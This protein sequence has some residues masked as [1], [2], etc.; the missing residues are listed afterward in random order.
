MRLRLVVST[1]A[2]EL[3]WREVLRPGRAVAYSA[4]T[5]VD[6][7]LGKRLHDVGFGVHG[8]A[9]L[10]YGAPVFPAARRRRGSYAIGGPGTI[11]FGSPVSGV[12]E[13]LA[14]GLAGFRVLD[15]G[16]VALRVSGIEPVE[17]PEFGSGRARFR[18]VTPVVMKGAGR[19][20]SGLR[21]TRQ[22]WLLPGEA[23]WA[24]YFQGNLR[25]KAET[26]GLD[27][28]VSLESV[29]WVGPKRSFAVGE[30]AKPGAAV[31]VEIAGAPE[32]L[33][34]LW[35]WGLGQANA[36]GMGWVGS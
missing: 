27:P 22:E 10:G 26:L 28:R 32:M 2:K 19:D 21:A 14:R 35:S 23:G 33:R 11:E 29:E 6:G 7:A 13:T 1:A 15:W 30:G 34:A 20:E 12:V 9:P 31:E 36:A 25:R 17:P 24:E 18:T 3:P 4:I 8:M 16:G 5:E